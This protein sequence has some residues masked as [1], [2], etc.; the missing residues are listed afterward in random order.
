MH[1]TRGYSIQK[2]AFTLWLNISKHPSGLHFA[3][4]SC[5]IL[6][7][8][9]CVHQLWECDKL[10][11]FGRIPTGKWGEISRW[12]R[13]IW[14]FWNV[15]CFDC[16]IMQIG[17][18][19]ALSRNSLFLNALTLPGAEFLRWYAK[20]SLW[21]H[22]TVRRSMV[23]LISWMHY[24]VI[25]VSTTRFLQWLPVIHRWV[26]TN[27]QTRASRTGQFSIWGRSEFLFTR[28]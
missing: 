3:S 27:C 6:E 7:L 8:A 13:F 25:H 4:A 20:L 9:G 21:N 17:L 1:S 24:F 5:L 28:W 19:I 10:L 14:V 11:S 22:L 2:L 15:T 16:W 23:V 18:A 26:L 12:V